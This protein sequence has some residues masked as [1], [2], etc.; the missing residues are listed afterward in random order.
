MPT[1]ADTSRTSSLKISFVAL[2]R[3]ASLGAHAG[4]G[5]ITS[6][7]AEFSARLPRVSSSSR[8]LALTCGQSPPYKRRF[9]AQHQWGAS[10]TSTETDCTRAAFTYSREIFPSIFEHA[11]RGLASKQNERTR[12]G[13]NFRERRARGGL[14]NV[15]R[16]LRQNAERPGGS[17]RRSADRKDPGLF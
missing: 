1:R 16:S 13:L 9:S 14:A 12:S 4:K 15:S 10:R 3:R 6:N 5:A 7:P 8:G 17:P 2:C 11:C